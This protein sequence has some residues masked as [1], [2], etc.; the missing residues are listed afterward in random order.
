M[1]EMDEFECRLNKMTK[2]KT[3]SDKIVW[4]KNRFRDQQKKFKK[5]AVAIW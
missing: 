3:I 5:F 2:I 4:F 1:R